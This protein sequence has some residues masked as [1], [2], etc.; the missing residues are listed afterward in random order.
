MSQVLS[1]FRLLH[2]TMLRQL[3][4]GARFETYEMFISLISKFFF[5]GEGATANRGY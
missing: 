3:S 4:L 1:A 2:F 5:G